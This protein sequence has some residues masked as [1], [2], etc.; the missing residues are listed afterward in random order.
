MC[1]LTVGLTVG[2]IVAP[3]LLAQGGGVTVSDVRKACQITVPAGWTVQ[4]STA[5]SPEKKI[6]ATVSGAVARGT[7]AEG[8][9]TVQS[10]MKPVKVL[11]DT[12]Q[13]LLYTFDPG[14]LAPG[15]TGWYA[16]A[17]TTPVCASSLMFPTDTSEAVL[18]AIVDSLT[19]AKK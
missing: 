10:A 19:P 7:F 5:Y 9:A 16:V 11:Q 8:K 3:A 15:K 6:S 1:V 12:P 2:A 18:R 17:N 13:R 14:S 4:T